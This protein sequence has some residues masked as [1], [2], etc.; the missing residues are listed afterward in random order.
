MMRQ[1]YAA[2]VVLLAMVLLGCRKSPERTAAVSNEKTGVET[3]EK[4][5]HVDLDIPKRQ[6]IIHLIQHAAGAETSLSEEA[7]RWA[8]DS[9]QYGYKRI[10]P[11][12]PEDIQKR[13]RVL[14]VALPYQDVA[15]F[16]EGPLSAQKQSCAVSLPV[17][18]AV[19]TRYYGVYPS[20]RVLFSPVGQRYVF[21][22]VPAVSRG[23]LRFGV[24]VVDRAGKDRKGDV[25]LRVRVGDQT[26]W[27]MRVSSHRCL[28]QFQ[29]VDLP[30]SFAT[31]DK[32][33][34]EVQGSDADQTVTLWS[35]PVLMREEVPPPEKNL[36]IV[37]VDTLRSD[38]VAV[39]PHLQQ[40]ARRGVLFSQAFSSS[41]WTRPSLTSIWGGDFATAL[42]QSV[43]NIAQTP[44]QQQAF[45]RHDRVLLPRF[46]SGAGWRTNAIGNN[47]F[48]LGYSQI[49]FDMGFDEV[50]DIRH[51]VLDTTAITRGT[52]AFLQ[53][54]QHERFFLQVHYD[55]P[56]WPYTPPQEYLS[57]I[58]VQ[59]DPSFRQYLAEAA[60]VDDQL[61]QLWDALG[62]L[63]LWEQTLVVVMGDH[64]EI[65]D[66][67]HNHWVIAQDQPTLYHHG[68]SA[69]DEITHVPLVMAG[70][71]VPAGKEV[72][73]QV[74]LTDVAPTVLEW[75]GLDVTA[76]GNG[77]SNTGKSLVRLWQ[78]DGTA[79]IHPELFIEGQNIEGIRT[80]GW[81]YLHRPDPRLRQVKGD[82]PDGPVFERSE[83]LYNQAA[84]PL[85]HRNLLLHPTDDVLK[86]L[87]YFRGRLEKMRPAAP[88]E[89]QGVFDLRWGEQETSSMR[90]RLHGTG[91][92]QVVLA[93]QVEVAIQGNT[94]DLL[95][96]PKG[97]AVV[98]FA[99]DT[100]IAWEP[101]QP[102]ISPV[103]WGAEGFPL[104]PL[105]YG[106]R[107]VVP[108]ALWE[109]IDGVP[110]GG[111]KMPGLWIRR[112][113][114]PQN[115]GEDTAGKE[116]T[117]P[118]V[119]QAMRDWGYAH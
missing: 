45:Y 85:Q 36:L 119:Q 21:H 34:F 27:Q 118:S 65:F 117:D 53:K 87:A 55:A 71:G 12:G 48:L 89:K 17:T 18:D 29:S 30:V 1:R 84:D 80:P 114:G 37:L 7:L 41:T 8:Y 54:H 78:Q 26:V 96:K 63:N 24:A 39:M 94:L 25:L 46:L 104:V 66:P 116:K 112:T 76:V 74:Q 14:D 97:H 16:P 98:Q 107:T 70:G 28:P 62:R 52:L 5:R 91:P 93:E 9:W 67:V 77:K 6:K 31:P 43:Q 100:D 58:A 13:F 75:M 86:K 79:P 42:G 56:H 35:D 101:L 73:Q 68:W 115:T 111:E 38:A 109:K 40:L 90:L 33:S 10:F 103:L 19:W 61:S 81:L 82:K 108:R 2:V 72:A 64:G 59:T 20:R 92:I 15:R 4:V 83:E 102:L 22:R 113:M 99:G 88:T 44:S 23:V 51:N 105:P 60:Y 95:L 57:R 50:D 106:R 11:Y 3:A 32:L 110:R 47:F 49:G 69:Y